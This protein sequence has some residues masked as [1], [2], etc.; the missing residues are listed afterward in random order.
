MPVQRTIYLLMFDAFGRG[1]VA[2]ST[3]TLANRLA[4][5]HRVEVISLVRRRAVPRFPLD[6]AVRLTVLRDVRS[7]GML[8]SALHRRPTRLS[9]EPVET[10]M[11]RLTDTVLRRKLSRLHPGILISTRPSLHLAAVRF[12]PE[13]MRLVGQDHMSFAARFANPRQVDV[14]TAAIPALDAYTV[15]T[16]AD[17]RDYARRLPDCAERIVRMPNMLSWP[18]PESPAPLLN[19]VVVAAGRLETEKG[20][21]RLVGAFAPVARRH[22]DWNLRIYGEGSQRSELEGVVRD[23]G[24]AGRVDLPGHTDDLRAAL[25]EASVFALSSYREGFGMALVEA[26]SVGVPPVSFDCP[27]GPGDIIENGRN[28]VLVDDGDVTGFSAALESLIEDEPRRRRLGTC[29]WQDA[30]A[31]TPGRVLVGWEG[32]FD[33]VEMRGSA[34]HV[35]AR[36]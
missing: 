9:P 4:E 35:V 28:G 26:M 31:Y 20:F 2:R 30:A 8:W 14:L 16:D 11:S 13:H 5:R 19:K 22:P 23:L 18:L 25:S 24:L 12:A 6:P 15:L 36:L 27:R 7:E 21:R 33:R 10:D 29:A 34:K 32:L 1:G 3:L 17:A